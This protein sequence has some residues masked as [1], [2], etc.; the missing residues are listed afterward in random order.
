[1]PATKQVNSG[2]LHGTQH[3]GQTDGDGN[4][5]VAQLQDQFLPGDFR[6]LRLFFPGLLPGCLQHQV[7]GL[8]LAHQDHR[9]PAGMAG[10]VPVHHADAV[11]VAGDKFG[12]VH[13]ITSL[14]KLN[15]AGQAGFEPTFSRLLPGLSN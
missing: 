11:I 7:H 3:P 10:P 14:Y 13:D 8:L 12:F 15:M 9:L 2:T 4:Q 1:M 6:L 5:S